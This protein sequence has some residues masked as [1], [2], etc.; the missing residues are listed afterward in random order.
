MVA[1]ETTYDEVL[2]LSFILT[3]FVIAQDNHRNLFT[4]MYFNAF[5]EIFT[6]NFSITK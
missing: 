3:F 2:A 4:T 1:L 5:L 6:L